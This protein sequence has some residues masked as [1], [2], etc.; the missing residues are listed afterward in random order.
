MPMNIATQF[1]V[2]RAVCRNV[3]I[4]TSYYAHEE[5][6]TRRSDSFDQVLRFL[7]GWSRCCLLLLTLLIGLIAVWVGYYRYRPVEFVERYRFGSFA[8]VR[9]GN[10]QAKWFVDG[11][12]Y[13][14]AVADAIDDAQHEVFI[15]DWQLNPHIFLKRPENGITSLD[16]RLDKILLKKANQGVR[17]YILVYWETKEVL[18]QEILNLGSEYLERFLKHENIKILHHPVSTTAVTN[19]THLLRWSHHEK[20]VVVD[21]SIAFVGG[22]DLAFGRWDTHS[23]S[24]TDDYPPHPLVLEEMTDK[25]SFA[26]ASNRYQ[27]WIGKDYGNTFIGGSRKE[28]DKPLEDYIN[29][30]EVPRMPW[31]D[32]ACAFTGAA[33]LDVAKHFIQRYNFINYSWFKFWGATHLDIEGFG[34]PTNCSISDPCAD[35][36]SIQVLRSVGSWSA[37][38]PHED[39]IHKAYL[40]AIKNSEHFIYIE[41]QF[42]ISTQPGEKLRKVYNEIQ[43]AL[44]ERIVR[45][46]E[47][48]EDFHVMIILP[49]QPEFPERW[50]TGGGKD[51]VTYW[52][53]ATLFS[54]EDSL[55]YKLKQNLSSKINLYHY[56]SVYGLRTHGTLNDKL[57]TEIVY[58]HSKI[59]IVDD[60]LAIIGSANINDRS[61]LGNRDSEVDVIIQDKDLIEG[62]MNGKP[63][64]VGKFSHGLRCH[65]LK[66]HLGLLEGNQFADLNV[67]DPLK[68]E[69]YTGVSELAN[70]NTRTYEVVFKGKILPT[71]AVWNEEDLKNWETFPG[72][73]DIDSDEAR[74]ELSKI[75]G[76]IV[77][78]PALF[79]QGDL[80][81]NI[82]DYVYMYVDNRGRVVNSNEQFFV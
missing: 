46:Y 4:Q 56:F 19:P 36:V 40:D 65:L 39:S 53:Y 25:K 10:S 78:F 27:R 63:Y 14:A 18:S 24:L 17:I 30:K 11:Q 51:S 37:G 44:C 45:A 33:V 48:G 2:Q 31:H 62:T 1:Y 77:H 71:D 68:F 29:R 5:A 49:L 58:V 59:M 41:N 54:G 43:Q 76:N 67:E 60:R 8:P 42:F 13:M 79:L 50:G 75:H 70:T 20:V 52:N 74:R 15:T 23:H 66:E 34:H 72:L 82:L 12:D 81:P 35:N 73:V 80:K 55:M 22:I 9:D 64:S 38:Q 57:V 28:F 69:F 21:R 7:M 16:W 47:N 6:T 26:S 61:L 3:F 32:I